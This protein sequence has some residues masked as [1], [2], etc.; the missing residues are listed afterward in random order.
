MIYCFTSTGQIYENGRPESP[1]STAMSRYDLGP[2]Y[3]HREMRT[4]LEESRKTNRDIVEVEI[5]GV[6]R[7][8]HFLVCFLVRQ[9]VSISVVITSICINLIQNLIWRRCF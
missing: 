6:A 4:R 9:S 5:D 2:R 7:G 1:T 3:M 8:T